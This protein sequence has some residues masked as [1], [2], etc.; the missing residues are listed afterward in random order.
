MWNRL[1]TAE[2]RR[3]AAELRYHPE[4]GVRTGCAPRG[5]GPEDAPCALLMIHGF[6][7][8]PQEFHDL[9]DQI[10]AAGWRVHA[11]LMPG[12][13]VS[14]FEFE[15]ITPESMMDHARA[16]LEALRDRHE[17]VAVLGHSLGGAV[18]ALLA[19]E[20]EID[21]LILSA[22]YF[23]VRHK[24]HYLLRPEQWTRLLG[25]AVRWVYANPDKQPVSR[26][27]VRRA[28]LSHAWVPMTAI[29]TAMTLADRAAQSATL[30]RIAAPVLHIHSKKDN[31]TCPRAAARAVE[32]MPVPDK[33]S[34]WLENSDHI[35]FWDY[36]R[37]AVA[38]A[39]LAFLGRTAAPEHGKT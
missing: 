1:L 36:D 5:C 6:S 13:G 19:A 12:H 22:P 2:V 35:L 4:T 23:A 28:I 3:H 37:E 31:V 34:V 21:G 25:P 11:P 20:Y 32:A 39:I 30:E 17:R 10:A 29:R 14:P 7:A 16:E 8:S 18:A 15:Q 26:K 27:E 33:E 9:P 38:R 24:W